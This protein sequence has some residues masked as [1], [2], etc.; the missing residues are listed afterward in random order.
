MR[1]VTGRSFVRHVLTDMG[2][3]LFGKMKTGEGL[4]LAPQ[5]SMG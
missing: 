3:S 4:C 1:P 5:V 2:L